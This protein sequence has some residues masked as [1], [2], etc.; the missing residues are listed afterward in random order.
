MPKYRI[1]WPEGDDEIE[2]E[3][4]DDAM[5][6]GLDSIMIEVELVEGAN[7]EDDDEDE[8]EEEETK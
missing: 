2:A 4:E 1:S 6:Q 5:Q 8:E 3:D 7:E